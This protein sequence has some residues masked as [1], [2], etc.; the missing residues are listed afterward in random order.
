MGCG[1]SKKDVISNVDVV[2]PQGNEEPISNNEIKAQINKVMGLK[3]INKLVIY[4]KYGLDRSIELAREKLIGLTVSHQKVKDNYEFLLNYAM[5]RDAD[6]V[7]RALH[8]THTD[9]RVLID[10]LTAR[11]KWQLEL[12]GVVYERKHNI[13]LLE[14]VKN[15]LRTSLGRLTGTQTGLGQL[16]LYIT[17]DQPERDGRLL[18]QCI[19][20]HELLIEVR[21]RYNNII[22]H[23]SI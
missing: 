2:P 23:T 21:I 6:D 17:T 18:Q 20:D 8:G 16:M 3:D 7:H 14:D 22:I 12:I 15:T 19:K 10:I 13:P 5:E 4:E 9:K 11:T 1:G